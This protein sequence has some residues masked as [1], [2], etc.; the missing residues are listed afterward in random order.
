[1]TTLNY[2]EQLSIISENAEEI[3]PQNELNNKIEKS[4]KNKI[5]LNIKLGC[6]PSRP[7]LHIGHSV[8]LKKLKDFQDLGHN[9]ILVIG[10][11]TAMIG[12]PT[13]RNKTRPQLDFSETKENAKTYI[14][15]VSKILNIEKV[16]IVYNSSWLNK[17]NFSDVIKLCSSFTVSQFLE[18][19]DFN[20]RYKNG[21]PISLH[22]FMYPLAQAYDSV[23]L[24]SDIE[25]G[26]TDQK[27]NLLLARDLQKE[28]NQKPQ[29]AITMPILEGTDG[30]TKMSKSYDNF[31]AFN[32]QPNEMYGK[33]MSISDDLIL[34]YFSLVTNISSKEIKDYKFMLKAGSTNPRDLKRKLAR[35]IVSTYYNDKM[36]LSAENNFDKIFVEKL[37]PDNIPEILLKKS[38]K[39]VEVVYDS[40]LVNSKSEIKRLIKQGG[41]KVDDQQILDIHYLINPKENKIIKIGKRKFLKITK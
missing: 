30:K 25:I 38:K 26:G 32:D 10:D 15:Q 40:K 29:I 18:R 39:I 11:F 24:R 37:I 28:N 22:E 12:D 9:V 41:V 36:S 34:K 1:M 31:I 17:I 4:F 14:N 33:V 23:F 27:F 13:G 20:Q 2:K 5:P 19:D 3:I 8:V 21:K 35:E 7:D 6:D 16:R